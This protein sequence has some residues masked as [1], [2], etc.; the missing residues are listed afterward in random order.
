MIK[1]PGGSSKS[2]RR[3]RGTA[4]IGR[5]GSRI[6]FHSAGFFSAVWVYFDPRDQY[7]AW[8]DRGASKTEGE[9]GWR[10]FFPRRRRL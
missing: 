2:I 10:W 6:P 8:S 5:S 7:L 9:L 3:R 1:I 4:I